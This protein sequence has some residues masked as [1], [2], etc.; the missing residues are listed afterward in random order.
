MGNQ[1]E[2]EDAL[3]SDLH[4]LAI[5]IPGTESEVR[6]YGFAKVSS[7][8]DLSGRNQTDAPPPQFIP[9]NNSAAD[10]QG[11]ELAVTARFSRIGVDTRSL[12]DWGTLETRIEG[13]FAGGA[14]TSTNAV[15]RLRQAWAELGTANFRVLAG[16]ANSVWNEGIY[17]TIVDATNLNQSFTRQAQIRATG[18]LAPGLTGMISLEAPETQ[19]TSVAG[20]FNP[21]TNFTG[22]ASPAFNTAPDLVGRLS[23]ANDGLIADV[24]GL[25]RR[26]SVRTAG[27]A[28]PPPNASMNATGWGVAGH[29]RMPMRWIWDGFGADEVIG[30][31]YYGEGIGRYFG[32]NTTG[33][34]ALSNIGLPGVIS[35]SLDPL[36]TYGVAV[37]YRRFW[38]PQLRSNVAYAY[39]WQD[40]PSYALNFVPGSPSAL[41]LNRDMQQVFA[42]LIWS[43]FG[44][45]RNGVFGSGAVDVGLEYILTRRDLFGGSSAAGSVGA[46]LGI[47]NRIVGVVV[48]RF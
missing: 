28:A 14:P 32:G 5:R 41:G 22:G 43:P 48:G 25:V 2:N 45:I 3:R 42:N 16:Q 18:R 33:Q 17:E 4:G 12:T 20:V 21:G 35:P 37:S 34:D 39:S 30:M 27:T 46:G 10:Q 47:T 29:V 38:A 31:A 26:L 23:Y 24:R 40:Y 8:Y 13:D 36:P 15:F 7:Y 11:G 19:F 44:A 9:L 6:L 1:F